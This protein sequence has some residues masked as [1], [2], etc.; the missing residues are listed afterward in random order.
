[1]IVLLYAKDELGLAGGGWVGV[2]VGRGLDVFS[3]LFLRFNMT[4]E[5]IQSER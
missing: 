4:Q 3:T 5:S 2:G 1:M